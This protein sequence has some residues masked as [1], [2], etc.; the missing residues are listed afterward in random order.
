VEECIFATIDGKRADILDALAD[1]ITVC[2]GT[3]LVYGFDLDEAM[4]RVHESNMSK[5][6]ADGKPIYRADGKILKGENFV[7]PYLDDLV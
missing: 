4:A 2:I 5:L 7:P 1:T 6:G 3:A